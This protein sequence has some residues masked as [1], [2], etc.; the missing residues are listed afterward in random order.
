[1][2]SWLAISDF[3]LLDWGT[4]PSN[5]FLYAH[6]KYPSI[7]D[8]KRVLYCNLTKPITDSLSGTPFL[9]TG[10]ATSNNASW[11]FYV[12][13]EASST[14]YVI[15]RIRIELYTDTIDISSLNVSNVPD[16]TGVS[17][18]QEFART[19]DMSFGW[20]Y[21]NVEQEF[22]RELVDVSA[23][24]GG[25]YKAM[26]MYLTTGQPSMLSE[27]YAEIDCNGISQLSAQISHQF[28]YYT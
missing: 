26:R 24:V 25:S 6:T 16:G 27:I 4:V 2:S 10:I 18:S 20:S 21:T 22:R 13:D 8:N 17:V 12:Y 19:N 23:G 28:L 7:P 9:F 11:K 3:K 1:M 5:A 14:H 15:G